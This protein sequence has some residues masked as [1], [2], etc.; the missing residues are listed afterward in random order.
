LEYDPIVVSYETHSITLKYQ[1]WDE[2][3]QKRKWRRYT[4]GIYVEKSD[5][6]RILIECKL[7]KLINLPANQKKF[8]AA[9]EWCAE[10]NWQFK[11]VY[12]EDIRTGARLKNIKYLW[13]Y[14]RFLKHPWL[15]NNLYDIFY[16]AQKPLTVFDLAT[17]IEP[18][19]PR[20]AIP[21]IYYLA[22]RHQ[23]TIPID[24]EE[25]SF[26]SPVYLPVRKDDA[27][28]IQV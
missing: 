2:R 15:V 21:S 3:T 16:A 5:H 8:T 4:P 26:K 18:E 14:A 22:F 25:I 12:E 24:D 19:N 17:I 9:S 6:S 27:N 10:R 20:L 1:D 11:I 28:G 7:K 13:R 23:L